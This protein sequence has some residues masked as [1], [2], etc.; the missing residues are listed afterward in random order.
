MSSWFQLQNVVATQITA[1]ILDFFDGQFLFTCW[2]SQCQPSKDSFDF[3]FFCIFFHHWDNFSFISSFDYAYTQVLGINILRSAF[4]FDVLRQAGVIF[5][6]R[7][8]LFTLMY[9]PLSSLYYQNSMRCLNEW[10][11][12]AMEPLRPIVIML[13]LTVLSVAAQGWNFMNENSKSSIAVLLGRQI[14]GDKPLLMGSSPS[15]R[16]LRSFAK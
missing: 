10:E 16:R 4:M 9:Y 14:K 6:F 12:S 8:F 3:Y 5:L 11:P 7:S 13:C 2:E 15:L 1:T